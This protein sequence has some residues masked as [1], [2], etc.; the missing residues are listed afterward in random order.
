M[1]QNL[2]MLYEMM[3]RDFALSSRIANIQNM[4]QFSKRKG[5]PVKKEVII[6][7]SYEVIPKCMDLKILQLNEQKIK[8]ILKICEK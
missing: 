6:K 2:Q 4:F 7:G 8:E 1:F 5:A 3:D